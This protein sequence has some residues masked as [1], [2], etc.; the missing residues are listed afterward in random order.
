[1][2]PP[3]ALLALLALAAAAC[4]LAEPT[5]G[6]DLSDAFDAHVLRRLE[7]EEG[8]EGDATAA[9][10]GEAETASDEAASDEAARDEA[11]AASDETDGAPR[12]L[13]GCPWVLVGAARAGSNAAADCLPLRLTPAASDG[14]GAA[15]RTSQVDVAAPSGV[16]FEFTFEV[17]TDGAPSAG[18]G[19]AFV[20]QRGSS[21]ALGAG[22]GGLG[23][24]GIGASVGVAFD[25]RDDVG[26]RFTYGLV[27]HGSV[28]RAQAVDVSSS[29]PY[30]LPG[31]I[32]ATVSYNKQTQLLEMCIARASGGGAD[33]SSCNAETLDLPTAL[34]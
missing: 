4:A 19:L 3:T 18:H 31:G 28:T 17:A 21:G 30:T 13:H 33:A 5:N 15:W 29:L 14:L 11:E 27:L 23:L 25:T 8:A 7:G 1:M 10:D 26:E 2:A 9:S 22:D 16:R 24:A 34:G 12:E 6:S 20:L 32:R